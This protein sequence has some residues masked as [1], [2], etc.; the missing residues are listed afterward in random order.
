MS[1]LPRF[2]PRPGLG[3]ALAACLALASAC[4][5]DDASFGSGGDPKEVTVEVIS[6]AF[7]VDRIF[8]S[9]RGPVTTRPVIVGDTFEP[10]LVWLTGYT[11]EAL[12]A[13]SGA[14][15]SLDF[16]CHTNLDW[17]HKVRP[18]WAKR[19][20]A[21]I[22][23]LT[24]GQTDVHLPPGF[25]LPMLSNERL[26]FNSQVLNLNQPE[27]DRD[28]VHRAQLRYVRDRDV[29]TPMKPLVFAGLEGLVTLE[30]EARVW[31]VDEPDDLV[32]GASCGLG[33]HAQNRQ[34]N[35]RRDDLGKRFSP[36]WVVPPGRHVYRTLVTD[37][38]ALP[39]DTTVH[40]IGVHVHPHSESLEL[41]DLTTGET[42]YKS[43]QRNHPDRL[44][45]DSV[46]YFSSR[47]GL[48]IYK[49]HQYEL[50]SVY[51]NPS[52]RDGDAMAGMYLYYLDKQFEA[53]TAG[54][55]IARHAPAP[56]DHR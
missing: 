32:E 11:V 3:P 4:T 27:I 12:D 14:P 34:S 52:D 31:N 24:Q 48:P 17:P 43:T 8:K 9:M 23:V 18:S 51:D 41:R 20:R 1:A 22:F 36:H 28:V 45:L 55:Q 13:E 38:I 46:E 5:P 40:F 35:V 30:D 26:V 49:D 7:H 44:G 2:W 33:D 10:E 47:E 50:I 42:V 54:S 29:D 25:G 53:R 39:Y 15:D 56:T 19:P 16:V 37:Q 21:R 6:D